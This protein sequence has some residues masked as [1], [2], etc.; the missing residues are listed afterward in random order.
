[1]LVCTASIIYKAAFTL[2]STGTPTKENHDAFFLSVFLSLVLST[3]SRKSQTLVCSFVSCLIHT[4]IYV[5]QKAEIHS[6]AYSEIGR[7]R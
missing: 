2:I 7:R 6:I 3:T 4:N 1:M 5:C